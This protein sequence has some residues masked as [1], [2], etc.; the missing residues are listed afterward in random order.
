M[1]AALVILLIAFNAQA[2]M[3]PGF[4]TEV[5]RWSYAATTNAGSISARTLADATVLIRDIY[6]LG[7]RA[8]IYRNNQFAGDAFTASSS[9]VM[10]AV[11]A[12]IINDYGLAVED[13]TAA[14]ST[15]TY[16][17]RGS[18]GGLSSSA[19]SYL[20]TGLVP[21]TVYAS[22]TNGHILL[23]VRTAAN[24]AGFC[25]CQKTGV[26]STFA[27]TVGP[28]VDGNTYAEPFITATSYIAYSD[29]NGTGMYL[30]SRTSATLNTLYKNG[31]SVGT[32]T[33]DDGPTLP[34]LSFTM[35]G[36]HDTIPVIGQFSTK[37][38]G[39]YSIGI[40]LTAAEAAGYTTA[41]QKFQTSLGR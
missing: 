16:V 35:F 15:W 23:Y 6:S 26:N 41:C 17:E 38:V 19:G 36:L 29:S 14:N 25:G 40:G 28:Y 33:T 27:L 34:D 1:K 24:Q 22:A 11:Q 2:A 7:I 4:S 10:G 30:A 8:K 9:T 20:S 21:S 3:R 31:T 13:S 5:N 37:V 12:P 32:N 18:S 39:C